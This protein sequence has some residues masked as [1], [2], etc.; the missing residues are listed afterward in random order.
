MSNKVM[1]LQCQLSLLAEQ[2]DTKIAGL[3]EKLDDVREV[4]I[5]LS[6]T[7]VEMEMMERELRAKLS[8]Y[9]NSQVCVLYML[10]IYMLWS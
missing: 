4:E 2:K 9:E 6:E 3:Q 10:H 5:K 1:R 8:L 7:V